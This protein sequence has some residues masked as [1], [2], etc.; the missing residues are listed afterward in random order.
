MLLQKGSCVCIWSEEEFGKD[1]WQTRNKRTPPAIGNTVPPFVQTHLFS[2]WYFNLPA[3]LCPI[4]KPSSCTTC[5]SFFCNHI[6]NSYGC[7]WHQ[8]RPYVI[9]SDGLLQPGSTKRH[10][11]QFPRLCLHIFPSCTRLL[12]ASSRFLRRMQ[13]K[14]PKIMNLEP[15]TAVDLPVLWDV[16]MVKIPSRSPLG[17]RKATG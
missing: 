8:E 17:Y 5:K 13:S 2:E 9:C 15:H 7:V 12:P 16:T 10:P 11:Q 4:S 6:E 1:R 14:N 3:K